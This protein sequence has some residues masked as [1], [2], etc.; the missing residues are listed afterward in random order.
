MFKP[1]LQLTTQAPP[2]YCISHKTYML[3]CSRQHVEAVCFNATFLPNGSDE[4]QQ[5]G[6]RGRI[7]QLDVWAVCGGLKVVNLCCPPLS[8][9]ITSS[10]TLPTRRVTRKGPCHLASNLELDDG[11]NTSTLSPGANCLNLVPLLYKHC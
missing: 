6:L 11:S 7:R 1:H 9:H 2:A 8:E 10:S 5:S 3:L 4:R